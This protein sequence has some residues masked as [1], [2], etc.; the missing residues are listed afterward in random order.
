[1][2]IF[3]A[4]QLYLHEK[5]MCQREITRHISDM[6]WRF[7][8]HPWSI[9]WPVTWM[10]QQ[11]WIIWS[12][13]YTVL[14]SSSNT[15]HPAFMIFP[16]CLSNP[17]WIAFPNWQPSKKL[18]VDTAIFGVDTTFGMGFMCLSVW[19]RDLVC[20]ILSWFIQ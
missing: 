1:M 20:L 18:W 8:W 10:L 15:I 9:T 16:S 14:S 17:P 12:C 19:V 3:E 13:P 11:P 2:Y 5:Y 4:S 7:I 6:S